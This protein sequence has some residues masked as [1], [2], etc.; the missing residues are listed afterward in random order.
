[1]RYALRSLWAEPRASQPTAPA[2]WD[3]ALVAALAPTAVIE[4]LLRPNVTWRP[5]AISVCVAL[6]VALL[7]R[8][9]HPFAVA[10]AAFGSLLV[11]QL[12]AIVGG[13]EW[14]GLYTSAFVL[15]L[16]YS[17]FRSG[18]GR[19]VAIGLVLMVANYALSMISNFP[20]V[21]DAVAGS[22]VFLFPALLGA[23]VRFRATSRLR[24]LEQVKLVEREQLARELHDIVAHHV[25]A[26]AIQAQAGRVLAA[27]RPRA[28]VEALAVIEEAAS[29]TLTEL[30]VMVGALREGEAA[31]LAPQPGVADIDRLARQAG[32][33]PP[34]TVELTGDLTDLRPSL[35]AAIYRLAQESITNAIR[36]ARHATRISVRV[37]GCGDCVRLTVCD[38]GDPSHHGSGA[39]PGFGL[40]GMAERVALLGGTLS[41][42]P[43]PGRGWT[44]EAALPMHGR[45]R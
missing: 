36:H 15:L 10:S 12:A 22:V 35:D 3:R 21:V 20:G 34:V 5:L 11:V 37:D 4:G 41:A 39:P 14:T 2:W 13:V 23:S 42:G 31:D 29:R 38:D 1:M 6:A 24:Q 17:L 28:A 9:T 44:V 18:A 8:R 19:E 25:S 45:S 43:G 33:K 40:A 27:T 26:I 16:P 30:R 7:W 32:D